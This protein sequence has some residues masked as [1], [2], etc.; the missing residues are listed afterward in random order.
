MRIMLSIIKDDGKQKPAQ[1]KLYDFTKGRTDECEQRIASY[2]AK[3]KSR[4]LTM[5]AFNY[6]LDMS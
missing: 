2:S 6:V 5:V 1:Y 4:K 3:P